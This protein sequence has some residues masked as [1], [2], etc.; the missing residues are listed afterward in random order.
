MV[1]YKK[2][3]STEYTYYSDA[4]RKFT[5]IFDPINNDRVNTNSSNITYKNLNEVFDVIRMNGNVILSTHPHRWTKSTIGCILKNVIF[6]LVRSGA[7]LL[8]HIPKMKKIMIKYY[9]LAKK[10]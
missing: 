4:G 1:D 7:K 5:M 6:K 8:F 10:I 2:K 9:Y 3:Y